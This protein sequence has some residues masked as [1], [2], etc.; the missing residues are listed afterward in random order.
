MKSLQKIFHISL[1]CLLLGWLTTGCSAPSGEQQALKLADAEQA[2]NDS[3][4]VEAQ[5]IC[6][7]LMAEGLDK[8]SEE[9]LGRMAILYMKLSDV[10]GGS[11]HEA[12]ATK[13]YLKAWEISTDSLAGFTNNLPPEDLQ[14]IM[15][16]NR[17]GGA[18][19]SPPDL[20]RE[21]E[22]EDTL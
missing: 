6:N 7:S 13:C 22:P 16:L 9:Q 12:D 10:P 4:W 8:L 19:I 3:D 11:A 14:Y 20:S 21:F 1:V 5:N 17:L 18:I 2:F 15:I